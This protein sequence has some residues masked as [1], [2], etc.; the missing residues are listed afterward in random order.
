MEVE[1]PRHCPGAAMPQRERGLPRPVAVKRRQEV[2][3]PYHLQ[4]EAWPRKK[5]VAR[6]YPRRGRL[7]ATRCRWPS[8]GEPQVIRIAAKSKRPDSG[9][10]RKA[11]GEDP[12]PHQ[13]RRHP[14]AAKQVNHP[15]YL[16][17]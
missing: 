12:Y 16:E 1:E 7:E 10:D 5:R 14:A 17:P 3:K 9:G 4:R 11:K 8:V 15:N 2:A 13:E 6:E